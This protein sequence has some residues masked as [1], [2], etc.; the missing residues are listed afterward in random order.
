[1]RIDPRI[2][3]G[4]I[5]TLECRVFGTSDQQYRLYIV[6]DRRRRERPGVGTWTSSAA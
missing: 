5:N 4:M 6:P 3:N 2:G 1:M